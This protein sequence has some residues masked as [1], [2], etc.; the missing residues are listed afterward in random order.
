MFAYL[1]RT[2]QTCFIFFLLLYIQAIELYMNPSGEIDLTTFPKGANTTIGRSLSFSEDKGKIT[3]L[4]ETIESLKTEI[5][6]VSL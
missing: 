5:Q 2:T 6:A 3:E 1:L 4:R